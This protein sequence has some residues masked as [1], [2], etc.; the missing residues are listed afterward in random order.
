MW[1]FLY[2]IGFSL[3]SAMVLSQ[4]ISFSVYHEDVVGVSMAPCPKGTEVTAASND[5]YELKVLALLNAERTKQGLSPLKLCQEM[6]QAA[7][8]HAKDM[9]ILNYFSHP[10]QNGCNEFDRIKA[11]YNWQ[12]V[13]EN[14]AASFKTP[15]TAFD[16]W[17]KSSGHYANMVNKNYREVG[18]GYYT[19]TASGAR[20]VQDFGAR[21]GVYPVVINNEALSTATASVDLFIYG[22]GVFDQMRI[23]NDNDAWGNWQPFQKNLNGWLL[24]NIKGKR[25]VTVELKKTSTGQVVSSV[26]DIEYMGGIAGLKDFSTI[27]FDIYPNPS[28]GD[29]IID[30]NN[31]ECKNLSIQIINL[32]GSQ[33][34]KFEDRDIE[35]N[36]SQ[37][38]VTGLM[39][40]VYLLQAYCRQQLIINSKIVV[41]S[42]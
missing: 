36:N 9:A 25:T 37:F 31:F 18:I 17:M 32:N 41:I 3:L 34:K 33:V 5:Q 29:F 12:Y 24:S 20:W 10:S 39:P 30:L 11:F 23:K 19:T 38:N 26:D 6:T 28:N 42:K 21:S 14:I 2:T 35:I 40:G 27:S 22:E 7:R 13:G 8:Y 4:S 1:N 15:E 16:A